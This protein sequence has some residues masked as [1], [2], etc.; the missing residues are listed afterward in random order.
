MG[1]RLCYNRRMPA[2][3]EPPHPLVRLRSHLGAGP[4]AI[5]LRWLDV[6]HR[7]LRGSPIWR[8]SQLSPQLFLG[9]Q[10]YYKQGYAAM[11]RRGITAI[12]N[13]RRQHSDVAKG[14]AG[15]RHLQLATTDNTPPSV[16]DL[17][18]GAIFIRDEI[19][20]GGKVYIHCAV[21]CG[22]APTMAAAY[23]ISA[24][25]TPAS[26]LERIRQT[27]PFINPTAKQRRVLDD[28][29]EAWAKR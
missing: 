7:R 29:A 10:H 21:G 8:L 5:A 9:G 24:G 28:F 14:I 6:A 25:H 19:E 2:N 16:Q 3:I 15:E 18:R 17:T 4:R 27:R 22:R 13:M 23:L 1:A 26:A 20:R 12:V 11:R